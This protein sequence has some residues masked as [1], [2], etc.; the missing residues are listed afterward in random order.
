MSKYNYDIIYNTLCNKLNE[1]KFTIREPNNSNRNHSLSATS[2]N[3][4]IDQLS[5]SFNN[6]EIEKKIMLKCMLGAFS[7]D[8]DR[9]ELFKR[10]ITRCEIVE[11]L[12]HLNSCIDDKL[13]FSITQTDIH[14]DEYLSLSTY[15]VLNTE[16]ELDENFHNTLDLI[17]ETIREYIEFIRFITK[18]TDNNF[19]I[20]NTY[21][22]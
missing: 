4:T 6:I 17:A 13:Y 18:P 1:L 21:K 19:I 10:K 14:E 7:A 2:K 22:N 16:K 12:F 3:F 11:N 8:K 20:T 9:H 5:I 15:I